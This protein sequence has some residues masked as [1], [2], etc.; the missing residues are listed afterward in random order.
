[1]P[2][3]YRSLCNSFWGRLAD[4]SW[5]IGLL[6]VIELVDRFF[7]RGGL[8]VYGIRPGQY[9]HW[10]GIIFAPFLHGSW[11]HLAG[12]SVSLLVLGAAVLLHGW[13]NLVSV[14]WVSALV[15]GLLV[16]FIGE[17]GS[18]HIG[19]SSVIFGYFGFLVGAGIYQ[20]TPKSILL[21][22]LVILF[23]GGAFYTMFPTEITRASRISWEGHLGGAL[24]GFLFARSSRHRPRPTPAISNF[25]S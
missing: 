22:V 3:S 9:S 15:A 24:G 16:L 14:T 2:Q 25:S 18:V 8:T 10:E 6:W 20:K 23:Y 12:N 17:R 5:F 7:L 11:S 1:M 4:L 13:K 19:A 21:A